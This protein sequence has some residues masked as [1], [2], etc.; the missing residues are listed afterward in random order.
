MAGEDSPSCA[1]RAARQREKQ[2]R[3]PLLLPPAR[4]PPALPPPPTHGTDH[5]DLFFQ[6][7]GQH[8]PCSSLLDP[9]DHPPP[10]P[11]WAQQGCKPVAHFHNRAANW[12]ELGGSS[13]LGYDTAQAAVSHSPSLSPVPPRTVP[14]SRQGTRARTGQRLFVLRDGAT[15]RSQGL[16]APGE[17]QV[18]DQS[19]Q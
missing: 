7:R 11:C 18:W 6:A 1:H 3:G 5:G 12:E 15:S 17:N 9:W 16:A 14:H 19:N 4:S 8:F 2:R 10:G 13:T